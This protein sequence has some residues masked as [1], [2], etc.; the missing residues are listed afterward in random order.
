M[1]QVFNMI[2]DF[3]NVDLVHRDIKMK[4][5][6]VGNVSNFTDPNKSDDS[7]CIDHK[8]DI[9]LVDFDFVDF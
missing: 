8:I 1:Y 7:E 5:F 2:S 4:N 6:V 3:N 9:K